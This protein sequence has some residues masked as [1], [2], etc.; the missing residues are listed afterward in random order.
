M[1]DEKIMRVYE[2]GRAPSLE[3]PFERVRLLLDNSVAKMLTKDP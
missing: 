2:D 1:K 3:E